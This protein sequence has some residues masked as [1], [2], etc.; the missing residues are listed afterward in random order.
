[1]AAGLYALRR[2][3]RA[4]GRAVALLAM[5]AAGLALAAAQL[6]PVV[7]AGIEGSRA[8]PLPYELA[9]EYAM[10]PADVL[11]AIVPG[12]FGHLDGA[13][14]WG[15][16]NFWEVV[17]FVGVVGLALAANGVLYGDHPRRGSA[18]ALAAFFLLFA[19]GDATPI[20][21]ILYE[22]VPPFDRFRAPGRALF[23][24]AVFA[25]ML[26]AIGFD[27]LVRERG[28]G[29]AVVATMGVLAVALLAAAIWVSQASARGPVTT[30]RAD[31]TRVLDLP[32]DARAPEIARLAG[33]DAEQS[34][35]L[36]L[37]AAA[38]DALARE[39]GRPRVETVRAYREALVD[40][41][42]VNGWQTLRA[43]FVPNGRS[44]RIEDW[45][46]PITGRQVGDVAALALLVAALTSGLTALL[47]RSARFSRRAAYA[48]ALLGVAELTCFAALQRQRF[49]MRIL[50]DAHVD[51]FLLEHP[52]DYRVY[53]ELRGNSA[54]L[55]G[56]RDLWGYDPLVPARYAEL[57]ARLVQVDRRGPSDFINAL[58]RLHPAFR[59]LRLKYAFTGPSGRITTHGPPE[60]PDPMPEVALLGAYSVAADAQ[61][62]LRQVATPGWDPTR[63]VIL[64][65]E[66]RPRP[67]PHANP[68]SARIVESSTDALTIEADLVA[69]AI[70]LVTDAYSTYWHARALEGSSQSDYQVLPADYVL[71]AVPLGA[72]YHRLRMEYS[73]PYFRL[74]VC[75]SIA[76]LGVLAF[77][78]VRGVARWRHAPRVPR[79]R[80]A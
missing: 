19:L 16:W 9:V 8:A 60:L 18:A 4:P 36:H 73:P 40:A 20:F 56:A 22:L 7:A 12:F 28:P 47:L 2:L 51:R 54:M 77:I 26:A 58:P 61:E 23:F 34:R 17:P 66:P 15:N 74:G 31:V 21:R 45:A 71:R 62:V 79:A 10:A 78:A 68:G 30:F 14:Y 44:Q 70:L 32:A 29:R 35:R 24:F 3:V 27:R 1:M 64:E 52:G 33:A 42:R 75:L 13:T 55:S 6:V 48:L 41:M 59:M 63:T 57:V 5:S 69:P 39:G 49:D 46:D 67:E 11:A 76:A 25:A 53:N 80:T 50:H 43:A 65:T 37:L 72:G 38:R